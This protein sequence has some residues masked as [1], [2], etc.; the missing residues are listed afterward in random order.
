VI[1]LTVQQVMG[2]RT[3]TAYGYLE[4][5]A[6]KGADQPFATTLT[7]TVT[8]PFRVRHATWS[9]SGYVEGDTGLQHARLAPTPTSHTR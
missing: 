3:V 6:C 9:A 8:T 2:R 1:D 5:T 4:P 7:V